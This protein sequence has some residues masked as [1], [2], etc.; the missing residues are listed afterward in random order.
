MNKSM[1]VKKAAD[2][3]EA[4]LD[5]D[6]SP[7]RI[8]GALCYSKVYLSRIFREE[9][10]CTV[11]KYIQRRRLTLAAQKLVETK[12]PIVEIAF[13]ACYDSQQAFTLAFK[14]VY[15]CSPKRYRKNGVF[16][17]RQSRFGMSGLLSGRSFVYDMTGGK[18]AA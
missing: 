10:G 14:Q 1:I 13:E 8:A 7:E 6:L 11:Y 15:E 2:Y 18:L 4:H 5:E 9:T 12:R 16:Y 3:I 17:P